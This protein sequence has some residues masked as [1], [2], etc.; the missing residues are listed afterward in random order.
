ML[1]QWGIDVAD[2]LGLAI[3]AE[4]TK[5]AMSLFESSGFERLTNETL[6]YQTEKASDK[7]DVKV[8]LMVR[9]P[10]RTGGLSFKAW[11]DRGYPEWY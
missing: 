1:V 7:E 8:S 5:A 3:Y 10:A 2:K 9:L 4:S 6:V 11:V